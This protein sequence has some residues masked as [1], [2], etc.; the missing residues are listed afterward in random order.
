MGIIL[1]FPK[2]KSELS[3]KVS[4]EYELIKRLVIIMIILSYASIPSKYNYTKIFKT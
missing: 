1:I 2:I 4:D 3:S